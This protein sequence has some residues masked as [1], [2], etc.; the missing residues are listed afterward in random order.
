MNNQIENFISKAADQIPKG[1]VWIALKN[2]ELALQIMFD[3]IYKLIALG[4]FAFGLYYI[5]THA[6]ALL[7]A[8]T[9]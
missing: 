6:P 7:A 3:T 9:K 2:I 4:I 5:Y 1:G 8:T